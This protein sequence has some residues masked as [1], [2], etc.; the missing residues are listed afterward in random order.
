MGFAEHLCA[1]MAEREMS[2]QQLARLVPCHPSL[3]CHYR[4]GRKRPS[5]KMAKLFD[6]ALGAGGELAGTARAEAGPDRRS[7]LAGGLLAGGVLA[8]APDARDLLAWAERHP[9][10]MDAA[11]VD[12]LAELL[13]AQRRADAVLG[14][15]VMLRPALAQLAAVENLVRQA[16]G[17]LRP[18]LL[19]VAQQWSQ[20]AAYQHRQLGD[21]AGDR[22]RLGQTL[23]WATEIGDRTMTA[24]VLINRG[25][26]ALLDGESG[27]AVGLAQAAQRDTSAAAG[28]RATARIC[29]RAVMLWPVTSQQRNAV[30]GRLPSSLPGSAI[31]TTGIRGCTGCRRPTCGASGACRSAS[32]PVILATTNLRWPS[33]RRAM[34][35]CRMSSG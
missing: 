11:V 5:A 29:K 14:S 9:P 32:W 33:W 23:E 13:T 17:P 8:I 7:V 20:F 18:A 34:R 21:S 6:V 22:G 15:G 2:G 30:S 27:T 28:P 35:R 12:S 3:V 19:N 24:T 31:T 4:R 26:T 10:R 16:R 25:E 1:L